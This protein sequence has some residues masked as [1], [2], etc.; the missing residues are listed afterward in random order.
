V[1]M[2]SRF[3]D[4]GVVIVSHRRADLARDCAQRVLGEVDPPRVVVVVNDPEGAPRDALEWLTAHVG[5]VVLNDRP[6]GFGANVNEGVR[7]LRGRCRYYFLANDDV[8]PERG[9]IRALRDALEADP[10]AALAGPRLVDTSGRPQQAAYRFPSLASE[11]AS[12]L[13]VPATLQRWL[14]QRFVLG[15]SEPLASLASDIW[16]VGAALLVRASAFHE[17]EGF[18]EQFFLYSEETDLFFRM[19]KRGWVA[20]R[21]EGVVAVHLGGESTADRRYRRMMG[22]SRQKYIQKHWSRPQRIVLRALL[23]LTYVWNS[24]YVLVRILLQPRSFR[25]KLSF[26]A[27]HWDKRPHSARRVERNGRA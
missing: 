20:R 6:R 7:R 18:D 4:T 8:L 5:V 10:T 1:T 3:P 22:L 26:W 19:T 25:E 27:V 12:A 21:C 16:L 24:A 2:R 14:W 13:I 11:V 17:V 23:G 15:G 9:A